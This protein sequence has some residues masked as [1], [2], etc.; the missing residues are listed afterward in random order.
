MILQE[1]KGNL[2]PRSHQYLKTSKSQGNRFSCCKNLIFVNLCRPAQVVF[3][4]HVFWVDRRVLD[5]I[6]FNQAHDFI[7]QF[8]ARVGVWIQTCADKA[9]FLKG[10]VRFLLLE[11]T[12]WKW[13]WLQFFDRAWFE[14]EWFT[15]DFDSYVK[16]CPFICPKAKLLE[17]RNIA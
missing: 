3:P 8:S 2:V 17:P 11:N 5:S 15:Y 7:L 12:R 4:Y 1:F 13:K 10:N 6:K 9:T 16:L 14:M